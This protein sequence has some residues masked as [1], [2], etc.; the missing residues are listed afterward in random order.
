MKKLS[1]HKFM[2]LSIDAIRKLGFVE[3]VPPIK[4]RHNCAG[5]TEEGFC[6]LQHK[7]KPKLCSSYWCGG[8][9]WSPKGQHFDLEE[10][11]NKVGITYNWHSGLGVPA[12][13]M[14]K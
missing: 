14:E 2:T 4:G 11:I 13:V 12:T 1:P 3:S 7:H 5:L 6:S 8:K 9:W 10:G